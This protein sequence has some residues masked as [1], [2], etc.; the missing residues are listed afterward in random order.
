MQR[1][2]VSLMDEIFEAADAADKEVLDEESGSS[3]K[4]MTDQQV[5]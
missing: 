2:Y 5:C 1:L 4:K 3:A